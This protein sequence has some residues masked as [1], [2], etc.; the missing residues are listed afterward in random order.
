MVIIIEGDEESQGEDIPKV[1][2]LKK[3][4]IGNVDLIFV[5]DSG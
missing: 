2:A 4:L 1:L 5:L 3:D